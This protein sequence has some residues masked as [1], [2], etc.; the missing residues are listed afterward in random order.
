MELLAEGGLMDY[1]EHV[2]FAI[3]LVAHYKIQQVL[4]PE[5]EA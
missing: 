3:I 2:V 4:G 5:S 1:C